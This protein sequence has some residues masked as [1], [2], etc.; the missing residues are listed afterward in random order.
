VVADGSPM[1]LTDQNVATTP[2]QYYRIE[3]S[4]P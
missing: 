1:I 4:A 2:Q 3:A